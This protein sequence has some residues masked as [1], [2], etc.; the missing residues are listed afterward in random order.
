[1]NSS[2]ARKRRFRKNFLNRDF[3]LRHA[4][5]WALL[6]RRDR[7]DYERGNFS[8]AE[9]CARVLLRVY[10]DLFEGRWRNGLR[11]N[12]SRV[13]SLESGALTELCRY[14]VKSL[15]EAAVQALLRWAAGEIELHIF[16]H[17][18]SSMEV[19]KLQT[20]GVRCLSLMVKP[21]DIV[22]F[23]HEGRDFLSFLIHDLIHAQL[24]TAG[25]EEFRHQIKFARWLHSEW[26]SLSVG[27]E[28]EA[29]HELEY[30][31]SDMNSHIVHLLKTFKS[32]VKRRKP[33]WTLQRQG[34]SGLFF[35]EDE[36]LRRFL[37]LWEK[38][39]EPATFAEKELL[40]AELL[41]VWTSF[42]PSL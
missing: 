17:V 21:E 34:M 37:P 30:M 19:L 18:P 41:K 42:G 7:S 8:G 38:L 31:A 35:E 5:E 23:S 11:E 24:M 40:H 10:E 15:P 26:P 29:L 25:A 14:R 39:N 6:W 2:T 12:P 20:Q 32:W 16:D 1:M 13:P 28:G 9:F 3:R 36:D 22:D 4:E 27:I 33:G